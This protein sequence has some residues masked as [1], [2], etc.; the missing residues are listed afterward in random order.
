VSL[1]V[2]DLLAVARDLCTLAAIVGSMG[3]VGR[4]DQLVGQAADL[5]VHRAQLVR[6][7]LKDHDSA[8]VTARRRSERWALPWMN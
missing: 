1:E 7:E 5:L 3:A 6:S 2:Y 8:Q 4:A